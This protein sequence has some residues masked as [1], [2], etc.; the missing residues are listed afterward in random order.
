MTFASLKIS[1]LLKIMIPSII[2]IMCMYIFWISLYEYT[3]EYTIGCLLIILGIMYV[4]SIYLLMIDHKYISSSLIMSTIVI[5]IT[6]I[7]LSDVKNKDKNYTFLSA[8]PVCS[9]ICLALVTIPFFL[10]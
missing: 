8:S 5:I 9:G 1:A 10:Y 6:I 4:C 3:D 7:S 2:I